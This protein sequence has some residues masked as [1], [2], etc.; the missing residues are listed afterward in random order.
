MGGQY[1]HPT[2]D[3]LFSKCPDGSHSPPSAFRKS[4]RA[5]GAGVAFDRLPLADRAAFLLFDDGHFLKKCIKQGAYIAKTG[6]EIRVKF[7]PA[8]M[9]I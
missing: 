7:P 4:C 8:L 1:F 3:H 5:L 2:F 6:Q 9:T